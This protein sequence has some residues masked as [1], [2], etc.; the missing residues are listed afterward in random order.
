MVERTASLELV[1]EQ[2]PKVFNWIN[3]CYGPPSIL[4]CEGHVIESSCGVQQCD[5]LGSFVVRAS[6]VSCNST[7]S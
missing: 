5:Q 1:R 3:F 2:F 4:D 6:T 7:Y